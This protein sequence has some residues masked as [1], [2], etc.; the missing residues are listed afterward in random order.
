MP[1]KGEHVQIRVAVDSKSA[2]ILLTI[3]R[4]ESMVSCQRKR[5]KDGHEMQILRTDHKLHFF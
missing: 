2:S 5:F 4:Q 3:P 1:D